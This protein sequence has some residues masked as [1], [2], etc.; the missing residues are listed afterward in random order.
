MPS[1]ADSPFA[2]LSFLAAPAILTNASTVLALGTSNRLARAADRARLL[3]NLLLA[4]DKK[5]DLDAAAALQLKDFNNAILRARL[6][7]RAL[8]FFYLGAGAFAAG[9]C[10]SLV[11]AT[12]GYYG[13]TPLVAAGQVLALLTALIG[14]VSVSAG[15]G[16]LV[17]ETR[18]GIRVLNDEQEAVEA[19]RKAG[20][21]GSRVGG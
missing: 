16:I 6:L 1:L 2:I 18:I 4:G 10:I 19:W 21:A 14:V 8:R 7:I 12:L 9:T 15:A 11:G 13:I 20:A 3:S 5:S 17:A